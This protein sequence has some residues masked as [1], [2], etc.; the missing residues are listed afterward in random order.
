MTESQNKRIQRISKVAHSSGR[1]TKFGVDNLG[2]FHS[3]LLCPVKRVWRQIAILSVST[4]V[5]VPVACDHVNLITGA[6]KGPASNALSCDTGR[7][8]DMLL[9]FVVYTH[10]CHLHSSSC[11]GLLHLCISLSC[12]APINLE[13]CPGYIPDARVI[14]TCIVPSN[15]SDISSLSNPSSYYQIKS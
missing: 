2:S 11:E 12:S 6:L 3:E 14:F 7:I 8:S 9:S 5:Y 1:W 15:L 10:A 13:Y 4:G